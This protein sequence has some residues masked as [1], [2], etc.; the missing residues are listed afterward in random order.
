[1]KI[2]EIFKIRSYNPSGDLKDYQYKYGNLET[3]WQKIPGD[4]PFYRARV[5]PYSSLPAF[6]IAVKTDAKRPLWKI[7]GGLNVAEMRI[8]NYYQK[9]MYGV[10]AIGVDPKYRGQ[11]VAQHLYDG[12]LLPRPEGLDG[13][14]MA[15]DS[16]SSGGRA[17]WANLKSRPD[18]EVTGW[19]KIAKGESFGFN[20]SDEQMINFFS[21]VGGAYLGQTEYNWYFEF[22]VEKLPNK[23]ELEIAVKGSGVKVYGG[24]SSTGLLARYIG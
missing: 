22:P 19:V 6:I 23:R 13:I 17:M 1:M 24:K 12:Y 15:G 18:I 3:G 21:K 20:Y 7:V 16:Q 5:I 4:N 8:D 14:L 2:N 11:G 9:N 10:G